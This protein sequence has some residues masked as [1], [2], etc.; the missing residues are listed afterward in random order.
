MIC[1]IESCHDS[2]ANYSPLDKPM[3]TREHDYDREIQD[4]I[5]RDSRKALRVLL[6]LL[7]ICGLCYV[8][9]WSRAEA[10]TVQLTCTAPTKNTDGSSITATLTY[11]AYWG[12]SASTLGN[13]TGLTGPGCAGSVIVPDA[14]AGTSVTYH[15]AV[16]ATAA[17]IE[18]AKSNIATKTFS[19]PL[20]TPNPPILLT[21][22]GLVWQASPN[23]TNFGW[24]LGAQ[25]GSIVAGIKCDSTR[26]IGTDY[27]R[28]TAPI[29]WTAGK[30][31]YVV[32]KCVAS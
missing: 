16:T 28:V 26:R 11:A 2:R 27:Y 8:L 13:R 17:G 7:T 30:K 15:F 4:A 5:L 14:T 21:E 19:T 12:T 32:A 23:Y 1:S 9:L 29:V 18:S 25:V 20:P 31:D 24:K 6:G 22:G 10:A 3:N